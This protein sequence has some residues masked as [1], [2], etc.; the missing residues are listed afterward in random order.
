M[1]SLLLLFCV[2]LGFHPVSSQ[3]IYKSTSGH[4]VATGVRNSERVFVESHQSL[5]MFNYQAMNVVVQADLRFL[6]TGIDSLN[7]ALQSGASKPVFFEGKMEMS[8]LNLQ[9][10]PQQPFDLGGNLTLNS[11]TKP[12]RFKGT[13]THL[14]SSDN[15]ACLFSASATI[16]LSDFN[17]QKQFA[18]YSDGVS[19][20][21]VQVV[22]RKQSR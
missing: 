1:K 17:L 7:K 2:G 19:I 10:H 22:L 14:S 21:I 15:N 20:E 9:G 4:I 18:E 6:E 11:M 13:L 12:V 8:T 16:R 5:V 3:I